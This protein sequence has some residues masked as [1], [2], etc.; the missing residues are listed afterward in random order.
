[1]FKGGGILLIQHF[2]FTILGTTP[3]DKWVDSKSADTTIDKQSRKTPYHNEQ[4]ANADQDFD[5]K[6]G[7]FWILTLKWILI[8]FGS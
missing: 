2:D 8:K 4:A 5:T 6:T 1:M 7:L 3:G